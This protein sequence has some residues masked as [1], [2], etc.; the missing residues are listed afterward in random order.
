MCQMVVLL[1]KISSRP[2]TV[3]RWRKEDVPTVNILLQYLHQNFKYDHE[4]FKS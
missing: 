1:I 4:D 3:Q 2:L